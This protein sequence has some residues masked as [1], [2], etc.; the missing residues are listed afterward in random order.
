MKGSNDCSSTGYTILFMKNLSYNTHNR[1]NSARQKAVQFRL[2]AS[3]NTSKMILNITEA[4]FLWT[5][6]AAYDKVNHNLLRNKVYETTR[7]NNVTTII[8]AMLNNWTFCD[9]YGNMD[10][11]EM[12]GQ[13]SGLPQGKVLSPIRFNIYTNNELI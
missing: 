8:R 6:L 4:Q 10:L 5:W 2:L 1:R 13:W 11:M 7:D 12:T 3:F 9:S